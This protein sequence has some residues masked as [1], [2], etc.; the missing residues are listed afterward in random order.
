MSSVLVWHRGDLR[1][2]DHAAVTAA[3]QSGAPAAGVVVLDTAILAGTSV[4]RRAL[5]CRGVEALRREWRARGAELIVRSGVPSVVLP[6]LAKRLGAGEVHALRSHTPYGVH[7]DDEAAISLMRAGAVLTLHDGLYVQPPGSVLTRDGRSFSVFTPWFR[8]WS[9]L[10]VPGPLEPPPALRGLE[11]PAGMEA[12]AVPRPESDVPLPEAGEGAALQRLEDFVEAR[13]DDYAA[14]RDRLDG[15]GG[16]RLSIDFALGALSPRT[17]F[18]R[19]RARRGEGPRKWIMEL[20]WRDFMADLLHHRPGLADEPMD[21]KFR[22]FPWRNDDAAFV[23]WRDGVTGIPVVDA[24]MR[25]LR[26]TGWMSG[27]ARM[28]AAQFLAKHLGVH[29]KK[30]EQVFRHLLLDG[31]AASNIGNWQW[32][33][34]LGVDNAPYFRV[35]NPVAQGRSHDPDGAWLRRWVPESDGDPRPLPNAIVE[36]QAARRDYL[37]A[38][39]ELA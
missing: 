27:R 32:A 5:F 1:V 31:D 38:V 7:R 30:G 37:A 17:A 35:F 24:A 18:H 14:T 13:L 20:A 26:A 22:A 19:V 25:E 11:L 36:L 6:E 29:W 15:S 4:R 12:G 21:A 39:E 23:A 2:H 16:A 3:A 9:E 34:G 28:V 8:R 33:A 10:P